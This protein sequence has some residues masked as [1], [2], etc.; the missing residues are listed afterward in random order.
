MNWVCNGWAGRRVGSQ[1]RPQITVL[2]LQYVTLID[3]IY[4]LGSCQE[5]FAINAPQ[6]QEMHPCG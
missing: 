2:C 5:H 6:G 3:T 1:R 4:R